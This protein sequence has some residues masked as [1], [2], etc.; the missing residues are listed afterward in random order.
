MEAR[1]EVAM[2]KHVFLALASLILAG[3]CDKKA[4]GSNA[5]D[6]TKMNER[7]RGPTPFQQGNSRADVDTTQKIRQAIMADDALS[8]DAKNIKIITADG[9][10]TLRGQVKSQVERT[11]IDELARRHAAGNRVDNQ[12]EVPTPDTQQR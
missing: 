6:K 10:I 8:Y 3:G 5:A 11:K 1:F 7:D 4:D 2:D 9:V 12:L